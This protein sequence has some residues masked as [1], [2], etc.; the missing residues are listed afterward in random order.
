M[1]E[2]PDGIQINLGSAGGLGLKTID[3]TV[4][5]GGAAKTIQVYAP[6]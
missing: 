3:I 6:Q 5:D 1:V 2:K 4:C